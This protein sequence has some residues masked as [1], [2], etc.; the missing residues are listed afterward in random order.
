M[1]PWAV[2]NGSSLNALKPFARTAFAASRNA[3]GVRLRYTSDLPDLEGYVELLYAT[4][5]AFVDYSWMSRAWAQYRHP[6]SHR[7]GFFAE[8][9]GELYG[10]DEA[11]RG[12]NRV[13]GGRIEGGLRIRGDEA[14]LEI[15]AGYERRV[16]AFPVDRY[17][18]RWTTI[19]FR[20]TTR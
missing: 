8:A 18:V 3:S 10:V 16:D 7:L 1:N 20:I 13:C 17:R 4:Q 11:L 14:A 6:V 5:P 9:H 12:K 2:P 15:F 19:G